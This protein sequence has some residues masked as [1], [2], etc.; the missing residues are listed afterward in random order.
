MSYE[1]KEIVVIVQKGVNMLGEDDDEYEVQLESSNE[2]KSD[3]QLLRE[4][5][6]QKSSFL[7]SSIKAGHVSFK[8]ES[9]SRG[10]KWI[11]IGEK[12]PIKDKSVVMCSV[13]KPRNLL[14]ERAVGGMLFGVSK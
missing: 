3:L 12:S 13:L 2:G 1:V 9:S 4:S 8:K 5:L 10:G 6:I 7:D 14:G 11:T